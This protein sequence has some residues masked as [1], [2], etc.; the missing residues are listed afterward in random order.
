MSQEEKCQS[1]KATPPSTVSSVV[2]DSASSVSGSASNV[3]RPLSAYNIFFQLERKR[4]LAGTSSDPFTVEETQEFVD[5]QRRKRS[6][7]QPRR[8]HRKTHGMVSFQEM[9]RTLA[10][11]WKL[12]TPEEKKIFDDCAASEKKLYLM[13]KKE[14]KKASDDGASPENKRKLIAKNEDKKSSDGSVTPEKKRKVL[15]KEEM[16]KRTVAIVTPTQESNKRQVISSEVLQNDS[17]T[18]ITEDSECSSSTTKSDNSQESGSLMDEYDDLSLIQAQQQLN[19]NARLIQLQQFKLRRMEQQVKLFE[20]RMMQQ[21]QA[22]R[23]NSTFNMN[24]IDFQ[25]PFCG[26]SQ[27]LRNFRNIYARTIQNRLRVPSGIKSRQNHGK[28]LQQR[29]PFDIQQE[30]HMMDDDWQDDS[31]STGP[32][33]DTLPTLRATNRNYVN[34]DMNELSIDHDTDPLSPD[35][36]LSGE[37]CSVDNDLDFDVPA[38]W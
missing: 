22:F 21:E 38:D 35:Y 16:K 36:D 7:P 28:P 33:V 23:T 4:I 24:P 14:E 18:V 20:M 1:V 17:C 8:L 5:E 25:A 30:M 29:T 13:E 11:R 37:V 26:Y 32:I 34:D 6:S 19:V 15:D 9:A 12:L 2:S 3:R 31:D 10:D 27:K